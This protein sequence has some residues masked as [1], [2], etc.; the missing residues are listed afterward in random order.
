M[1]T[2]GVLGTALSTPGNVQPGVGP[3]SSGAATTVRS[4]ESSTAATTRWEAAAR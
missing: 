3:P 2:T 4:Y 1:A